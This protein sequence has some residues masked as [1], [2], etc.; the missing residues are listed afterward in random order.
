[1]DPAPPAS[2]L[3][4]DIMI[5]GSVGAERYEFPLRVNTKVNYSTGRVLSY[6][7]RLG[8]H[9]HSA[10]DKDVCVFLTI[11]P[12]P[13]P[14]QPKVETLQRYTD[15]KSHEVAKIVSVSYDECCAVGA[16][17]HKGGGAAVM[18]RAACTYAVRVFPWVK[19]FSLT[20]TSFITTAS[21]LQ[22]PL[23][24]FHMCTSGTTWYESEFGAYLKDT[25]ANQVYRR[26]VE[27]VLQSPGK[28]LGYSSI[29]ELCKRLH[30]QC[31]DPE[32][33]LI[34]EPFY[35]E[36]S[37]LQ[38]FFCALKASRSRDEY[39]ELVG[40]WVSPLMGRMFDYLYDDY[41]HKEWVIPANSFMA[42]D[43]QVG[44]SRMG[45]HKGCWHMPL[46]PQTLGRMYHP[47]EDI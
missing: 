38:E 25:N 23:P 40:Q 21:G 27:T 3:P 36:S 22:V 15:D 47:I 9:V 1:M 30:V 37:T 11:I 14:T 41:P 12:Q 10:S 16:K 6:G 17:L 33:C 46:P 24:A 42:Q 29:A 19:W 28:K 39:T 8:G 44:S 7:I 32:A 45:P 26:Q 18:L 2:A 35:A 4:N 5:S 20:D 13:D 31:P 43:I 34:M